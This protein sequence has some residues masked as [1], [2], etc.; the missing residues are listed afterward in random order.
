MVDHPRDGRSERYMAQCPCKKVEDAAVDS[1]FH[2]DFCDHRWVVLGN[3]SSKLI[4]KDYEK[5]VDRYENPYLRCG[6]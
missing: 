6:R 1:V 2:T 3:K 5:E 4:L